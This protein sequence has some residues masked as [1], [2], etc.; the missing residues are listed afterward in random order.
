MDETFLAYQGLCVPTTTIYQDNKSTILLA[1]IGKPSS[2]QRTK[3]LD[4]RYDRQDQERRGEG[5]ILPYT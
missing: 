4:V 3:H 2:S 5:S 1:K